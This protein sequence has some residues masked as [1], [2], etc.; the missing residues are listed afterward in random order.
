MAQRWSLVKALGGLELCGPKVVWCRQALPPA[1]RRRQRLARIFG[2]VLV[3]RRRLARAGHSHA[4]AVFTASAS[5]LPSDRSSLQTILCGAPADFFSPKSQTASAV[6]LI[7]A[8]TMHPN[9]LVEG[10]CRPRLRCGAV[11]GLYD[12]RQL[13]WGAVSRCSL[14][15]DRDA[16]RSAAGSPPRRNGGGAKLALSP[17]LFGGRT[18]VAPPGCRA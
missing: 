18:A 14:V 7:L 13:T 2:P 6:E 5:F 16:P 17:P 8:A 12:G 4:G 15:L 1:R 3:I 10:S 9:N 11:A